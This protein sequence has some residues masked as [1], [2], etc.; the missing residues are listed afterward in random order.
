MLGSADRQTPPREIPPT[1][2]LDR[3]FNKVASILF[4]PGL[5]EHKESHLASPLSRIS[6]WR[7]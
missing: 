4:F 6:A 3:I 7:G 5:G 2:I 1:E